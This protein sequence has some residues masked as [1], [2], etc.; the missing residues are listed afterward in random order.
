MFKLTTPE[1]FKEIVGQPTR[2]EV[3]NRSGTRVN[4]FYPGFITASFFGWPD[5]PRTLGQVWCEGRQIDIGQ[6][7]PV[8]LRD[9]GDLSRFGKYNNICGADLSRLDLSQ[10]GDL[11]ERM[12]FD[13]LTVWPKPDRLP[14]GFEPG[15]RIEEGKNPGL[16]VRSLHQEGINGS[17]VC[18]AIVDGI[19]RR[20]HIEYSDRIKSYHVREAEGGSHAPP[21]CSIA[22]GKTCGVAPGASLHF[23]GVLTGDNRRYARAVEQI[24]GRNR[25]LPSSEKVRV[26]SISIGVSQK[27][28]YDQWR[29]VADK[30]EKAGILVVTCDKQDFMPYGTLKQK[31]G[32]DTDDPNNHDPSYLSGDGNA[33]VYVPIGNRSMASHR[34]KDV[35]TFDT[36]GGN[37]WA[38]PYLAGLAALAF[39]VHP[40]I[41]PDEIVGLWQKTAIP[42]KIGPVVNPR[43]FIEAVKRLR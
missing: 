27:D 18:I 9:E 39:Q 30:A 17:G 11:L 14:R 1:E 35:Y 43:R 12:T 22:V 4:L 15:R 28:H 23:Y 38:A 34:G 7:R 36:Y 24:V 29:A 6:N 13:S 2:E 8:V 42:T 40:G 37:S 5:E 25:N 41:S 16:G 26:I 20:D 10:K 31:V 21:V 33:L 32:K 3:G 19:L